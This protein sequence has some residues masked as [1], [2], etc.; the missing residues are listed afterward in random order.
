MQS[1]PA[2][3]SPRTLMKVLDEYKRNRVKARRARDT[4]PPPPQRNTN[5]PP[6]SSQSSEVVHAETTT[7]STTVGVRESM[8]TKTAATAIETNTSRVVSVSKPPVPVTTAASH[9][10]IT[11]NEQPPSTQEKA[12]C[13]EPPYSRPCSARSSSSLSTNAG[14]RCSSQMSTDVAQRSVLYIP[15]LEVAFGFVAIGDA[16]VSTVDVTNRTDHSLRLRA[17]LS[18]SGPPFALLDSQ[19]L[20]LDAR[21]TTSLRIEFSP[22]QN[23]RFCTSL[24]ISVEGGGGP[25]VKYRMPVRGL[26]GAAVVTVKA[27]DDLRLSR[28]GIYILQSAYESTFSFGLTNS[29]NRRAFARI[30][31]LYTGESNVAEHV[32][33]DIRPASG[34]VIDRG[35]SQVGTV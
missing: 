13:G 23:A 18:H 2:S 28:N 6:K 30:N 11:S 33:V 1:Q 25:Q 3:S 16:A 10:P 26:G 9:A 12:P 19:I 7:N 14:V 34:V 17:K 24:L 29:G 32:P 27:R 21:R 8:N 5:P 35:E 22:T 4:L 20:V 31:V 15:Q